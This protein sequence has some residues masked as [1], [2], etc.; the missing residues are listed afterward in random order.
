MKEEQEAMEAK[1]WAFL[2]INKDAEPLYGY[3]KKRDCKFGMT[4]A[5]EIHGIDQS[6]A[7][8]T[9][10]KVNNNVKNDRDV[11]H[12]SDRIDNGRDNS[13]QRRERSL[14]RDIERSNDSRSRNDGRRNDSRSRDDRKRDDFRSRDDGRRNSVSRTSGGWDRDDEK[15]SDIRTGRDHILEISGTGRR[16]CV[17]SRSR[18]RE[19]G[20]ISNQHGSPGRKD[21]DRQYSKSHGSRDAREIQRSTIKRSV[22]PSV[23]EDI[24][25]NTHDSKRFKSKAG[26]TREIVELQ[27][28]IDTTKSNT[29]SSAG[30]VDTSNAKK[31]DWDSL[32]KTMKHRGDDEADGS[33]MKAVYYAA[34]ILS[35]LSMFSNICKHKEATLA[36]LN[37][38][39]S[40]YTSMSSLFEKTVRLLRLQHWEQITSLL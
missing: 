35:L 20:Y 25:S 30:I 34:S 6:A 16:N 32:V 2:E 13:S 4:I 12:Q 14:S 7:K 22:S 11:N 3:S 27:T 28:A 8:D 1:M 36:D 9:K 39:E 33:Q 31:T 29:I 18:S 19:R 15:R 17:R 38:M 5:A 10:P 26:N 37:S 23:K 21:R 24:A 40:S